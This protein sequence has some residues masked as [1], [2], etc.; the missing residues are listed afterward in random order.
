[1]SIQHLGGL[2][3]AKTAAEI[4]RLGNFSLRV[5][6]TGSRLLAAACMHFVAATGNISYA[7]ELGEFS[8]LLEDPF[9]GMDVENGM[10]RV[11]SAPGLGVSFRD[12]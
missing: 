10:L 7:C 12:S 2:Q 6:A 11:P 3:E 8:R 5:Q 9:E 1:M 4:C